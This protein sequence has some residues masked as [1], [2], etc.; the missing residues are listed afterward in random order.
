MS[1]AAEPLEVSTK[2]FGWNGMTCQIP[3]HWDV[4]S[5]SGSAKS[6]YFA[7]DDEQDRRLEIK[8]ERAGRMRKPDLDRTLSGYFATLKKKA[9]SGQELRLDDSVRVPGVETMPAEYEVRSY[10][11]EADA[12]TRGLIWHC[13]TCH[14]IVIAECRARKNRVNTK[15]MAQ[16]LTSI[17]CHCEGDTAPWAVFDFEVLV[18]RELELG[19]SRLQAGLISFSF[20]AK[21]RR[22]VVDRL[23]M[24][25]VVMKHS[26]LDTYVRDVH[27]KKLRKIRLRFQPVN[28]NGHEG[29]RFEGE[30]KRLYDW[31]PALGARIRAWRV[32]DHI[33]GLT[34]F[35]EP[36]NR[37]YVIRAEGPDCMELA[38]KVAASARSRIAGEIPGNR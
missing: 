28:W 27:Y 4:T 3:V 9:K 37:I 1:D 5:V 12:I 13:S 20:S 33:A 15:E 36:T 18:P 22:L 30:H 34:W 7:F 6:G 19:L 31:I 25:Q 17:R 23:G 26:S 14:R 11:W 10:G 38:E 32:S 2:L 21:K 8:Y 29:F 24:G 35:E 16:V